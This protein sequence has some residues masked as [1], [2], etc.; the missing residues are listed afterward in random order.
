M[1]TLHNI[2]CTKHCSK[3]EG[4]T[5]N[6][7]MVTCDSHLRR[8]THYH[9][10]SWPDFG[11]PTTKS[12]LAMTK[13]I[14]PT[15]KGKPIV[16][17]CSGGVGRTG[18]FITVH[19]ALERIRDKRTVDMKDIVCRIR[20]QREGMI[21]SQEQ[22]KFCCEAVADELAPE[23]EEATSGSVESH[24]P[25]PPHNIMQTATPLSSPSLPTTETSNRETQELSRTA[26]TQPSSGMATPP[27]VGRVS[28]PP[29]SSSP[30]PPISEPQTPHK[31]QL[32]PT[33]PLAPSTPEITITGPTP[34]SSLEETDKELIQ[35]KLDS[36][37]SEQGKE[38]KKDTPS[39]EENQVV[40]EEGQGKERQSEEKERPPVRDSMAS[41][42]QR[43]PAV[44]SE[45]SLRK[46]GDETQHDEVQEPEE[47]QLKEA[48]ET[49]KKS[50]SSSPNLEP[51][52]DEQ[53]QAQEKDDVKQKFVKKGERPLIKEKDKLE[54]QKPPPKKEVKEMKVKTEA[55]K[56]TIKPQQKKEKV[57]KGGEPE[58]P[59][60]D[61]SSGSEAKAEESGKEEEEEDGGFSI[62][63]DP[64][65]FKPPPKKSL[66]DQKQ[67]K[68]LA[69]QPWKYQKKATPWTPP[70]ASP[71]P[72]SP[73]RSAPPPPEKTKRP[74]TP[75]QQRHRQDVVVRN[76]PEV[77]TRAIKKIAIPSIFGG[78]APQSPAVSP[79]PPAVSPK[80]S[81]RRLGHTAAD[82]TKE[83]NEPQVSPGRKPPSFGMRVLPQPSPRPPVESQQ[84][85]ESEDDGVGEKPRSVLDMISKLQGAKKPADNQPAYK[86]PS[87]P[88][89][90]T[91]STATVPS[92]SSS[93]STPTYKLPIPMQKTAAK[94]VVQVKPKE[95]GRQKEQ[96]VASGAS[97]SNEESS[98]ST[99]A[100][101]SGVGNVTRLLARF[102]GG[103]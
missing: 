87:P 6:K 64:L 19:T 98:S 70:K 53:S 58:V 57:D 3:H 5:E 77:Y 68:P 76:E 56:E 62:G 35:Q 16:V 33:T 23:Q 95:A 39:K 27:P 50:E 103:Q 9:Y 2:T 83:E 38:E 18:A 97:S 7:L 61:K 47:Q 12:F 21:Q 36:I 89:K 79:K 72:S 73:A 54:S 85:A 43:T 65:D 37:A 22:Y 29:P 55:S 96:T 51:K 20:K 48:E 92:S 8:I 26:E 49:A 31:V 11:C 74:P 4:F 42:T 90:A 44:K 15:S 80:P 30:P 17:H 1:H 78:G 60:K 91:W 10:T 63:D 66:K 93:T 94:T 24:P 40:S 41:I 32:P 52:K 82:K 14:G 45:P 84:K 100:G 46:S 34:R 99:A 67:P 25:P 88:K 86:L 102:Q 59:N 69:Q 101:D 75:K 28:P 71:Q 81:P 13:A